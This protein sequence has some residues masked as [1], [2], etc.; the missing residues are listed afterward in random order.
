MSVYRARLAKGYTQ[1]E[2]A[3]RAGISLQTVFAI[4]NG[5]RHRSFVLLKKLAQALD[6]PMESLIPAAQPPEKED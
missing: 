4:E 5:Y 1:A 3:Q 6:V 2:L